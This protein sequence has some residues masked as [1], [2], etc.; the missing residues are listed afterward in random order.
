MKE[1]KIAGKDCAVH[2]NAQGKMSFKKQV[3]R[4]SVNSQKMETKLR[5]QH[6]GD[7]LYRN[8]MSA[9]VSWPV[10]SAMQRRAAQGMQETPCQGP[11][12]KQ[13]LSAAL[14][15]ME[16][17]GESTHFMPTVRVF[18]CRRESRSPFSLLRASQ[19]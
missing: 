9:L 2:G 3:N 13:G 14:C 4:V 12:A 5:C 15:G 18:S 10:I 6:L 16:L 7:L 17:V 11:C 1:P 8:C 19:A